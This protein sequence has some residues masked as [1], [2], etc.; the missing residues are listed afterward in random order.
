[1][2]EIAFAP[3][4]PAHPPRDS[5]TTTPVACPQPKPRNSTTVNNTHPTRLRLNPNSLR[6]PDEAQFHA[7]CLG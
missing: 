1:M 7:G 5:T 2:G 6:E 3:Q 4:T